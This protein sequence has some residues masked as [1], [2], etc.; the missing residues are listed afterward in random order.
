VIRGAD[1]CLIVVR[2]RVQVAL[3]PR[4]EVQVRRPQAVHGDDI[5]QVLVGRVE[6]THHRDEPEQ[7]QREQH[8]ERR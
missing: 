7:R 8:T 5:H 1:S 3:Q 6:G 4:I 2:R